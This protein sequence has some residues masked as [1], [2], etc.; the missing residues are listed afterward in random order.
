MEHYHEKFEEVLEISK[1]EVNGFPPSI[2]LTSKSQV[3]K[4]YMCKQLARKFGIR[5]AYIS[6]NS[7]TTKT[8]LL[9]YVNIEGIEVSSI[10]QDFYENGGLLVLE[11]FDT[12]PQG[13]ATALNTAVAGSS[14]NSPTGR[15]VHRHKDFRLIVTTNTY[16]GSDSDYT[17]RVKMDQ[18]SLERYYKIDMDI[19]R[20]LEKKLFGDDFAIVQWVRDELVGREGHFSTGQAN[21][22]VQAKSLG[23]KKALLMTAFRRTPEKLE[24]AQFKDSL[25]TIYFNNLVDYSFEDIDSIRMGNGIPSPYSEEEIETLRRSSEQNYR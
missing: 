18:A 3:G 13:V 19:D 16:S 2:L 4:S 22:F 17:A 9:G 20:E 6:G 7:Q 25:N 1:F 23:L 8:D 12:I 10:F 14:M 5:Y 21:L 15:E 11:E 24:Y